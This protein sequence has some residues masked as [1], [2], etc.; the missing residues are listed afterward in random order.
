M[1]GVKW[2]PQQLLYSRAGAGGPAI[3]A[4]LLGTP[5]EGAGRAGVSVYVCNCV[6]VFVCVKVRMRARVYV[7]VCRP[8]WCTHN[9]CS[10]FQHPRCWGHSGMVGGTAA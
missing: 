4:L 2:T 9:V 10:S 6:R 8:V 7:C 1:V 3:P 5:A